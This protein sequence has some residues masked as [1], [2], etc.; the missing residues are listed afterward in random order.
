MV[1]SRPSPLDTDPPFRKLL[2]ARKHRG[3]ALFAAYTEQFLEQGPSK[4]FADVPARLLLQFLQARFQFFRRRP[5][6]TY[7]LRFQELE[8]PPYYDGQLLTLVEI[9]T[10]DRPFLMDSIQGLLEQRGVAVRF[11]FHPIVRVGRDRHGSL[12]LVGKFYGRGLSEVQLVLI[13]ERIDKSQWA[14][15][16]RE[17]EAVLR[18]VVDSVGDFGKVSSNVLALEREI[19]GQPG[20]AEIFRI[21]EWFR[22][23]NFIFL[24]YLP[25]ARKAGAKAASPG[26]VPQRREGLGL[27]GPGNARSP[28]RARLHEQVCGLLASHSL[29]DPFVIVEETDVVSSVHRRDF[30]SVL[31][32]SDRP[33]KTRQNAWALVGLFTHHSLRL[34]LTRIPV[35]SERMQALLERL[36]LVPGSHKYKEALDFL[37]GMPRREL[38]RMSNDALE[39][40]LRFFLFVTDQPR[41]EIEIL[42]DA[43]TDSLRLLVALPGEYFPPAQMDGIREEASVLLRRPARNQWVVRLGMVSIF[44]IL[45]Q[46]CKVSS[47]HPEYDDRLRR[48]IRGQ[49]QSYEDSLLEAW[50]AATGGQLDEQCARALIAALPEDYRV[51]HEPVEILVDLSHL[52]A[53]QR[54]GSR[55]FALRHAPGGQGVFIVLYDWELSA[56]SRIMPILN[57]LRVYVV[58]ERAY[59]L[60]LPGK[61]AHLQAFGVERSDSAAI[62]PEQHQEPL[63][64]LLFRVLDGE[65]ENDPL[66]GLLFACGFSW[67]QINLMML[68]RNYLMQVGSVYTR[69]TINETLIR[70]ASATSAL[71]GVFEARFGPATSPA[72]RKRV[73]RRREAELNDAMQDIDN[74]TEDRIFKRL[75]NLVTAVVRTNYYGAGDEAV[76]ALKFTSGAIDDLPPPRPLY[77]IYVHAPL[78]EGIHLRGG[79]IA[80][81]G[82]RYSDRP[83]DFRTEVLGLMDTQ[84]KKNAMIVPVGSKG[85]FVVKNLAPFGGDARRA[86]DAQYSVFMR[87]LLSVSDNLVRGKIAPPP[88]VVRHDGDDPY[89]VVA[90]DKGTAHLSDT[91]NAISLEKGFW[92]RDAFASGGSNGY[93]HKVI[94]ITAKGAWESVKRHFWEMGVDVRRESVRVV[95]IGDMS[96]DVFGNGMLLSRQLKLVGAFNHAHIFIDPDPDPA[97]SFKERRRLFRRPGSAWSDYDPAVI[98]KGG[99]VFPRQAK[100]IRLSPEVRR[101]LKTD[102]GEISGEEA[103]RAL[104]ASEVD[105]IWNGGIGTYLKAKEESHAE[106]GDHGN[107][108]VRIDAN[109][110]HAKVIG[111][112]G[113]LGLTQAG[114]IAIDLA[115][116]RL[117]TDAIDNA[118][119]VHMSDQEVNL[120]I[121]LGEL[122][123]G[124]RIAH[125]GARNRWLKRLEG[126]VT[127]TVIRRN[128]LQTNVIS[129]D[130][131]RSLG[132]V[133]PF[134]ALLDTLA[135]E[136]RVDRRAER[137]PNAQQFQNFQTR[138]VGIP[139]PILSVLLSSMKMALFDR[140][141]ASELL[142]DPYLKNSYLAYFPEALRK[143]FALG[144][145]VHPL[146][147][148]IKGTMVTNRVVDQAGITFVAETAAY[149]GKTW[150][151]VTRAYLLADEVCDGPAI[152]EQV[153][154]Q[155]YR[156]PAASQYEI[157]MALESF[158]TDFVREFLLRQDGAPLPFERIPVLRRTLAT[159]LR[160]LPKGLGARELARS[161]GK[162]GEWA[163]L[164]LAAASA[165]KIA[166]LPYLKGFFAAS[167]LVSEWGLSV[168]AVFA[169]E[170]EADGQ[171]HFSEAEAALAALPAEDA[172]RK[173]FVA[174]L[175][176]TIRQRRWEKMEAVLRARTT[177][178]GTPAQWVAHYAKRKS[179]AL[180]EYRASLRRVLSQK[181]RDVVALAVVVGKMEHL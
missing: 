165:K 158:L 41:T 7:C 88:N 35:V 114:R 95:G 109:E 12:K 101:L 3:G 22:D 37:N 102:K 173:Q 2:A 154:G 77:E 87:A 171:F 68:L 120:K 141:E 45:F 14:D 147:K 139:R 123:A 177:K 67:R 42:T 105:L 146:E 55:Q 56:L 128:Y 172:W 76:I 20:C 79:M 49:L 61:A 161:E 4:F 10:D 168:S 23:R 163:G 1:E 129:M 155:D 144:S 39:P 59:A 6:G 145:V 124:G 122:M 64:E 113:N 136:G 112:G 27:L 135:A 21:L 33:A 71:F 51:G 151:E 34:D 126:S 15:L 52:E 130:R 106:V 117:N 58:E 19:A 29:S 53:L 31:L 115:G 47:L 46:P 160:A 65:L 175:H 60:D 140:L 74:L 24:G 143:A 156:M 25:F 57:N 30:I 9:L 50:R 127:S 13:A 118:G 137:I 43:R 125:L 116:T 81:G 38:F 73:Q 119:G 178:K 164:G 108:A 54:E 89:L 100:A 44:S 75:L 157:L 18:D 70:R 149:T 11:V 132:D 98:S 153:Y 17:L 78:M 63:R 32:F 99:G 170:R 142:D 84:M 169:L 104:L 83:D 166:S 97:L 93:D 66:N 8:L 94:G 174:G 90:A 62:V 111:E 26:L 121:L 150:V 131:L 133:Q 180:R 167:R 48:I 72:Q 159:Y 107:D 91:A 138:H 152:R 134:V 96:G 103:I 179:A 86:G 80:R 36:G 69:R 162:A 110:C 181:E 82:I 148:H 176:R 85:G 28:E 16:Q 40:I 5:A 92:L